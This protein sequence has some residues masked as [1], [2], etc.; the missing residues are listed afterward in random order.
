MYFA[1]LRENSPARIRLVELCG[2]GNFLADQIAA[3]PLLLDELIDERLLSELPERANLARDLELIVQ[4]LREEDDPERQ[5]EALRHFQRAA[6]F[7]IAVADLSD[8]LPVM[9]VSDRLTDVAELI[10]ERA[11]QPGAHLRGRVRQVG[12]HGARLLLGS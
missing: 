2:R 8:R 5:V 12:R 10:V 7:R 9:K 3:Y 1:L 4:A 6:I 11:M